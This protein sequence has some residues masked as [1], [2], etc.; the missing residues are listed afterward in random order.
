MEAST[1]LDHNDYQAW[2]EVDGQE[3]Q[4]YSIDVDHAKK[5]VTCWIAS[6][7]GKVR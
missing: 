3:L 7:V 2:I 5:I 1:R 6:E 4:C